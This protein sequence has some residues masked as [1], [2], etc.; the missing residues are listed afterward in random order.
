M[1]SNATGGVPTSP[2][3]AV[4]TPP[5]PQP[6]S[7]GCENAENCVHFD[8]SDR[9]IYT[10]LLI[11]ACMASCLLIIFGAIRFKVPIYFGRRR[12]RNLV[13]PAQDEKQQQ[14]GNVFFRDGHFQKN[15]SAPSFSPRRTGVHS[16]SPPPFVFTSEVLGASRRASRRR[17]VRRDFRIPRLSCL[18]HRGRPASLNASFADGRPY[19]MTHRPPPL[20]RPDGT[21]TDAVFGWVEHV[22]RVPDKELVATA[23]IDALAFIRVCQFGI[24]LFVPITVLAVFVLVPLHVSGSELDSQRTDFVVQGGNTAELRSGLNSK[25]MR[26]TAANLKPDSDIYWVHVSSFW[27][28]ML[29]ATWLMR[30][31]TR[32]F[33]LLRQLYLST[34]GDTNLWRAVHMPT[35]IL[36]QMLVQGREMEAEVDVKQIRADAE[37]STMPGDA[38]LEGPGVGDEPSDATFG[39]VELSMLATPILS[40]STGAEAGSADKVHRTI[41]ALRHSLL[42]GE[43]QLTAM[44]PS[45]KGGEEGGGETRKRRGGLKELKSNI[46]ALK[47]QRKARAAAEAAAVIERTTSGGSIMATMSG[48]TSM[49]GAA[50]D[51]YTTPVHSAAAAAAANP[52]F[53]GESVQ[54]KLDF[55][56]ENTG[57]EKPQSQAQVHG[58]RPPPLSDETR[59]AALAVA[60]AKRGVMSASPAS[61]GS[62][63]SGGSTDRGRRRANLKGGLKAIAAAKEKLAA[64]RLQR[65]GLE[66]S[67]GSGA[68]PG[69]GG[70]GPVTEGYEG[71]EERGLSSASGSP[72]PGPTCESY[73]GGGGAEWEGGIRRMVDDHLQ[74]RPAPSASP[75]RPSPLDRRRRALMANQ[76]RGSA[77]APLDVSNLGP[78]GS[79]PSTFDSGSATHGP[80]SA[81]T[82]GGLT[83]VAEDGGVGGSGIWSRQ[84]APYKEVAGQLSA[85]PPKPEDHQGHQ[86]D[87]APRSSISAGINALFSPSTSFRGGPAPEPPPRGAQ[88]TK[89]KSD[90]P[91][92]GHRRNRSLPTSEYLATLGLGGLAQDEAFSL[93]GNRLVQAGVAKGGGATMVKSGSFHGEQGVGLGS[94]SK[95]NEISASQL[96]PARGSLGTFGARAE[97]GD[98]ASADVD[99]SHSVSDGVG[100][101]DHRSLSLKGHHR[102]GSANPRLEDAI[103]HVHRPSAGGDDLGVSHGAIPAAPNATKIWQTDLRRLPNDNIGGGA[104]SPLFTPHVKRVLEEIADVRRDRARHRRVNSAGSTEGL[105]AEGLRG[106]SSGHLSHLVDVTQE[107]GSSQGEFLELS[108][109]EDDDG[110]DVAI[111][112]DWWS[113]TNIDDEEI[114]GDDDTLEA[115][116]DNPD[117]EDFEGSR[118]GARGLRFGRLERKQDGVMEP[119]GTKDLDRMERGNA[120]TPSGTAEK[121]VKDAARARRY[122]EMPVPDVN[123]RRTVNTYDPVGQRL[124]SVWAAN[125]TVLMTDLVPTVGANG[126]KK[127]PIDAVESMFDNLFPDEFRGIIPVFDHREVDRLL[128]QRDEL[129]NTLNK[130]K[131]KQ[132]RS[133]QTMYTRRDWRVMTVVQAAEEDLRQCEKAVVLAR[134][135]ALA[136]EPG[137]SCF[138]VFA[139]QKAAAEAAQCLLHSGSRRN[140][141]VQPAPG[142]DNVN[143]QTLLYRSSDAKWRILLVTPVIVLL[144][145]FPSG[146]FTVGIASACIVD[147]PKGL[148][149]FLEWYCSTSARPFKTIISGLLPPVLLTLWE[150]FIVSFFMLYLVQAQNVHSS[151]SSTD[152]RFLRYY[153]VWG[154]VNVLIGGISGGALGGMYESVLSNTTYSL[155]QHLGRV[156]PISSNFF[157]VFVFFRAVY[158][159]IQRLIL[160]HP[161]VICYTVRKYLCC[162]GCTVTPRDRTM[163]YSPRGM[164][165]GREVGVFLMVLMLG[166]TFSLVAPIMAPACAL[167]FIGN[168]I[169]WRYHVLYVYE[170]GYESNGAMWFSVVELMVW[171]L[172]IAQTFISCVLF[173]KAAWTPGVVLY[174]TVPYYLYRY[175][176]KIKAEFGSGS[177]WSVPLGEASKAPPA[178]FPGEVYTHPSLRRAA[179]GWHP[180]VGKVWRGYPGVV[181][182]HTF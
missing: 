55:D 181:G 2:P 81:P 144:I 129:L 138:V 26:A 111:K 95:S 169:V 114:H 72:G 79:E 131:E 98:G 122:V 13:G 21:W 123:A 90:K 61:V 146:I 9:E 56:G 74:D 5:P 80:A 162:L 145:L 175:I 82:P 64:A 143:W 22:L 164:R 117:M 93:G 38:G 113:G 6:V 33:A 63:G 150:V 77:P 76:G 152:R 170:R 42:F 151:L 87:R 34:A 97:G 46:A 142:P 43:Q 75:E 36:Q 157:L 127:Y 120:G 60:A 121:G 178:D 45:V 62:A 133:Y 173:S 51:V 100:G 107:G 126:V 68:A 106:G 3:P 179:H 88:L 102:R 172:L 130:V 37:P 24:Q 159:P 7:L 85:R 10:S 161:G 14:H 149:S 31:H 176:G 96:R 165:M 11:Y 163:K 66:Q 118:N 83:G 23:G 32:T 58:S 70:A 132:K 168:F 180:D 94:L 4:F 167:F 104:H 160:P 57:S 182:K 44:D 47:A 29:Y 141:R 99:G 101:R 136:A 30:R 71:G 153:F 54:V 65:G 59:D 15:A 19:G 128:D 86:G 125:Y 27:I 115:F 73:Q 28:I 40:K 174:I 35:S 140:F 49:A 78:S 177:A 116:Y 147:P 18:T 12:L 109:E 112:H 91:S 171:S 16:S 134:E 108:E 50:N 39:G 155:Q 154:F 1:G 139:T 84:F 20:P 135:A 92:K 156:L 158:L 69:G 148:G 110:P 52:S 53:P 166:L 103:H 17:R 8:V 89:S 105:G 137:P 67:E 25:I 48:G 124:V 119:P 41:S